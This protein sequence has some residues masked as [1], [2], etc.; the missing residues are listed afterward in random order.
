[1]PAFIPL[2]YAGGAQLVRHVAM[3]A[4][5]KAVV[6]FGKDVVMKNIHRYTGP[7]ARRKMF[8][9]FMKTSDKVAGSKPVQTL[10]KNL[11][12]VNPTIRKIAPDNAPVPTPMEHS[13]YKTVT[14][15]LRGRALKAGGQKVQAIKD[16]LEQGTITE[17]EANKALKKLNKQ[18]EVL[19][20]SK[21]NPF[22]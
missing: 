21:Q 13:V 19:E 14:K 12:K 5:Q 3:K 4:G 20:K 1:M 6:K 22:M 10:T 18:Q 11:E 9:T 2:L 15:V 16:Q 7:A 17:N 8:D